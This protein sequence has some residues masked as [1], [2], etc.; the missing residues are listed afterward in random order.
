MVSYEKI[1]T[2]VSDKIENPVVDFDQYTQQII[3]YLQQLPDEVINKVYIQYR[4]KILLKMKSNPYTK[5]LQLA[6]VQ[7]L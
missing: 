2:Q 7:S 5:T 1:N 4:I 3:N 6:Y